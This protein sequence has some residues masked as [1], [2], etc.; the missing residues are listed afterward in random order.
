M[1]AKA[2]TTT[3]PTPVS[4]P[5][6]LPAIKPAAPKR[7]PVWPIFAWLILLAAIGTG[8]FYMKEIERRLGLIPTTRASVATAVTTPKTDSTSQLAVIPQGAAADSLSI[9][10]PGAADDVTVAAQKPVDS[11]NGD[12]KTTATPPVTTQSSPTT[13]AANPPA[14]TDSTPAHSLLRHPWLRANGDSGPPRG[15]DEGIAPD[16]LRQL[17]MEELQG[18]LAL[19]RRFAARGDVGRARAAYRDA[20]D[21]ARGL[22][23]TDRDMSQ[24][25]MLM[26]SIAQRDAMQA[27]QAAHADT[28]N[29]FRQQ[30]DCGTLFAW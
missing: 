10:S 20:T 13:T 19:M 23:L 5:E 8:V 29:P 21:E 27:C 28:L 2:V 9:A 6:Q 3:A 14:R 26:L 11:P 30:T 25:I 17:Q 4:V 7:Q 18:H 24:R 22:Q 15:V 1:T 16:V 12:K